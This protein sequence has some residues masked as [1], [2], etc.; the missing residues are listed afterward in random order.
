MLPLFLSL[1]LSETS[2]PVTLI[3]PVIHKGP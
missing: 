1:L 3:G 2:K